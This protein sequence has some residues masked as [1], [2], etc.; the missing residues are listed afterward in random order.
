MGVDANARWRFGQTDGAAP[1]YT[2]SLSWR[3][4]EFYSEDDDMFDA[5]DS[6]ENYCTTGR[7]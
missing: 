3:R 4:L 5:H 1:G 2:G 7:S 6:A